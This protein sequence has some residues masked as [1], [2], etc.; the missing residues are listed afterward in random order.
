MD[1][2]VHAAGLSLV[3]V[4][5]DGHRSALFAIPVPEIR[6]PVPCRLFG[7]KPFHE[8]AVIIMGHGIPRLELV[9]SVFVNDLRSPLAPED[10][11]TIQV[12]IP[13]RR[14]TAFIPTVEGDFRIREHAAQRFDHGKG[15]TPCR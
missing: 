2:V 13:G 8:I 12:D 10:N 3:A 9:A 4:R 11:F 14:L 7:N 15:S 5:A 6:I 1:S